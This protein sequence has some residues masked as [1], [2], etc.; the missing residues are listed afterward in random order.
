MLGSKLKVMVRTSEGL[1]RLGWETTET[2]E[3]EA[4]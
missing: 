4:A 1:L 3:L 2:P